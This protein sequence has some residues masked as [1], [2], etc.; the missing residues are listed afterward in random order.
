FEKS[1]RGIVLT[2]QGRRFRTEIDPFLILDAKLRSKYRV[3][4]SS[5]KS[6]SVSFGGSSGPATFLLPELIS[7]FRRRYPSMDLHFI[8]GTSDDI[9]DRMVNG[10]LDIGVVT[11]PFPSPLLVMEPYRTQ[12]LV[13]FVSPRHRLAAKS[14]LSFAELADSSIAINEAGEK[15]SSELW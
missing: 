9:E 3:Q 10:K 4:R 13:A 12:K 5:F 1:G 2:P 7:Q 15:R 11:E 14:K 6:E 8:T